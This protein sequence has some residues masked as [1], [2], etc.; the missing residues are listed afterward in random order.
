MRSARKNGA[1]CR[2]IALAAALQVAGASRCVFAFPAFG[3]TGLLNSNAATDNGAGMR[4]L[5]GLAGDGQGHWVATWDAQDTMGGTIGTDF[6]I[7]VVRSDDD[8][9]S[10][11]A[12]TALNSD[13][14]VDGTTN[15]ILPRVA[16]DGGGVW[17]AVWRRASSGVMTSRSTDNGATWSAPVSAGTFGAGD[18]TWALEAAGGTWLAV[19]TSLDDLGG[20]IGSDPDIFSVR[21]T[22][23]GVTWSTPVVVNSDAVTDGSSSESDVKIAGDGGGTWITTWTEGVLVYATTSTDDGIT[24]SPVTTVYAGTPGETADRADVAT[25]GLGRWVIAWSRDETPA[26]T[27]DKDVFL[28]LS[29]DA[30]TTWSSPIKLTDIDEDESGSAGAPSIATDGL[31]TWVVAFASSN[32]LAKTVGLKKSF[33]DIMAVRSLDNAETWTTPVPIN[34]SAGRSKVSDFE[35]VLAYDHTGTW[36]VGWT[37]DDT[38]DGTIGN[39]EDLLYSRASADCPMAPA[40]GCFTTLGSGRSRIKLDDGTGARDKLT[41]KWSRGEQTTPADLGDPTTTSDYVVCMYDESSG[42]PKLVFER[43]LPAGAQC[44][45][46]PCWSAKSG[47]FR[48]KDAKLEQGGISKL[49]IVA[50]ED[51]KSKLKLAG[52]RPRLGPPHLPFEQSP[53]VRV[54]LHNLE[55]AAC[56]EATF[57]TVQDNSSTRFKAR[58][59]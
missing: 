24:W 30:G 38:L 35:P 13:A 9:M 4:D 27:S 5:S 50:G 21:S 58:S 37:S 18:D 48:Y 47:G 12:T 10:W 19:F 49:Q 8:G 44:K 22:D 28:T 57:S 51:G 45:G 31:G 3:P 14:A 20:T 6:D 56:W 39:D 23:G 17:V 7:L 29:D 26:L 25:D 32:S 53:S 40:S 1:L 16:T 52:K 46:K 55:T 33:S 42:S 54:Q 43:D 59:D 2:S 36:I 15:D 11:S 34:T 41:W